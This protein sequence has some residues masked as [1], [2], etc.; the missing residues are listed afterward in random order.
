MNNIWTIEKMTI[1]Q[2][3]KA[4]EKGINF[5]CG[6]GKLKQLTSDNNKV[7]TILGGMLNGR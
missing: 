3:I 5:V 6:D 4:H 2:G 1:E 7:Q